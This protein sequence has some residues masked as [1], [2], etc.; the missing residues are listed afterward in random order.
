M[1]LIAGW[2]LVGVTAILAVA[3]YAA[4][5][6]AWE[7]GKRVFVCGGVWREAFQIYA[8]RRLKEA[9]QKRLER[10]RK[11]TVVEQGEERNGC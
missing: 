11:T 6:L 3:A 8:T 7:V 1:W 9:E 5:Y 4:A 10:R 2:L